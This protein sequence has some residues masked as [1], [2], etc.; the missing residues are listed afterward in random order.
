MKD[1]AAAD[2][3]KHAAEK[4]A[5]NEEQPLPEKVGSSARRKLCIIAFCSCFAQAWYLHAR[6]CS[7]YVS[8]ILSKANMAGW[9]CLS[10]TRQRLEF[11]PS[12]AAAALCNLPCCCRS[13]WEAVL[14][15]M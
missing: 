6:G 3:D 13:K 8:T 4:K 1:G 14:S 11:T 5:D 15:I 9:N 10:W 7:C 2:K 12:V